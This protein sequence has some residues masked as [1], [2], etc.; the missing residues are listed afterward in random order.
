[1]SVRSAAIWSMAAQYI[2]FAVQF[3]VSVI[4]SRYFLSPADVGVFSIALSAAMLISVLQD[5]GIARYVAGEPNLSQEQIRTCFSVSIIFAFTIG[6]VILG[7]AWPVSDFYG[8]ATLFPLLVIIAGSYLVIPFS[9][10]PSALLSRNMAFRGLFFVNVGGALINGIV[11][12]ALAA[13]GYAALSL[14]WALVAQAIVRAILAQWI[15]KT[16]IPLPLTL[17][18]ARPILQFGSASSILFVSGAIGTR[19]P[20]LIIGRLLTMT[21]VGLF[22]RATSLTGQ[23]RMLVAGAIGGVF[24]PAFARIRDRGDALG[25]PYTRV[26]AGYCAV[27][28]PA[29]AAL[30]VAADPLVLMLYGERWAEVAPLVQWIAL[31]EIFLVAVPLHV[32]LPILLGKIG[33]LIRYN[34]VDTIASISLLMLAATWGVEEAAMSRVAYAIIWVAIYAGF[35]RKLVVFEWRTI[36]IIYLK[37]AVATVAAIAPLLI[38]YW[39]WVAPADMQFWQLLLLGIT[40]VGLWLLALMVTA[41]PAAAEIKAIATTL[42]H[43][44]ISRWSARAPQ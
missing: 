28:W 2:A 44:M 32:E 4:I 10:V 43:S 33:P 40:G 42:A 35:I 29:M 17:K 12:I 21:A 39:L 14:A 30:A 38:G 19:T 41:H 9:I 20:E 25:P 36:I 3:I 37:S 27:L 23:L 16:P 8:D 13:A 7:I 11:A 6:L 1:M 18:G 22:G 5:F 24:Y 15:S 26:V 31:A 34:I